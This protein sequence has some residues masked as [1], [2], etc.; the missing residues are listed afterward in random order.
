M[1]DLVFKP[2]KGYWQG[3]DYKDIP[4]KP[5]KDGKPARPPVYKH[6]SITSVALGTA[7]PFALIFMSHMNV[8]MDGA[9]NAYGPDDMDPL[10]SLLDAGQATHY[11]GLM[12]VLPTAKNQP[13]KNGMITAPG[14]VRVKVDPRF[15]DAQGYLPVVQQT[16]PYA[17][18]FVS[19]TSKTNPTG[20]R[21]LYE[22][23]HYLDAASVPYYAVSGGIQAQGFGDGNFGLAI[24]LDTFDTASFT[25]LGGEGNS[26]STDLRVGECSYRVFLDIGGQPKKRTDPWP[27]NNFPTCFVLCPRSD[28]SALGQANLADNPRDLAAFIALQA[29][30]NATSQGA[31]AVDAFNT[32]VAKGRKEPTLSMTDPII[33]AFH[34]YVYMAPTFGRYRDRQ[35]LD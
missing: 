10:D 13:D 21:S 2:V 14:G 31:S 26:A 34:K 32:W 5:A 1:A 18:Y 7:V 8:D 12:S 25:A 29:K 33:I 19:T 16:G 23:S 17:G 6:V 22:Q 4:G 20:S 24:R 30:T 3:N 15:P 27:D 9:G 28:V 35:V 11:Y